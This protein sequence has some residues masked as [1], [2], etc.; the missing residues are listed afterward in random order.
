MT[1]INSAYI[2]ELAPVASD[3]RGADRKAEVIER[4]I[5]ARNTSEA[6]QDALA[7]AAEVSAEYGRPYGVADVYGV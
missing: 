4:R 5:E 7:L 6:T 1:R 2:A 3:A